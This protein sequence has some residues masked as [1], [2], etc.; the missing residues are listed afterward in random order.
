MVKLP[1]IELIKGHDYQISFYI[2][3]YC[4]KCD[5]SNEFIRV[6]LRYGEKEENY[7]YTKKGIKNKQWIK[8]CIELK[9]FNSNILE[10]NINLLFY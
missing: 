8:K 7:E 3:I 6:E 4:E 2:Y 1:I 10:V 5:N 9:N